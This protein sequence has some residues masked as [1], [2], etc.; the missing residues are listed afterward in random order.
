[1]NILVISDIHSNHGALESVL[2]DSLGEWELI[3][4]L[5][6][7]VGYGPDPDECIDTVRD[8]DH[9][10]LSGNHDQA[11]LDRI[12]I[13]SFNRDAQA[14]IR[15]TQESISNLNMAYLGS[16]PSITVENPFTLAHASPRNP[17]WEYI[18]DTRTAAANFNEFQTSYCLV[19]HTHVPMVCELTKEGTVEWSSP[20]YGQE[21][22]L[23]DKR[24]ITN[25]GSVGQPRDYDPRAAYGLL[26]LEDLTWEFRRV[27]YDIERTQERMSAMGMPRRLIERLSQGA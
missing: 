1:M 22:A 25:P 18:L 12:D 19:G 7:L 24:L 4:F 14:A 21:L 16:L 2:E 27:P 9:I 20:L 15:W 23:S 13:R 26:H 11:V 3:W 10:A 17:V 8:F 5:G 6:D